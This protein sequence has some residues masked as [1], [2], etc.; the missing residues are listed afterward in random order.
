[1]GVAVGDPEPDLAR[2]VG[3]RPVEH[4]PH[5]PPGH[6]AAAVGRVDPHRDQ[7][8][9]VRDPVEGREAG[10]EAHRVAGHLHDPPR[11]TGDA[12]APAVIRIGPLPVEAGGEGARRVPQ[13][14]QAQVAQ[15]TRL[16]GG[17][18]ADADLRQAWSSSPRRWTRTRLVEPTVPGGAPATITTRA[19][20]WTRSV[21]SSARWTGRARACVEPTGGTRRASTPQLI[22]SWLRTA[23]PGGNASSGSRVCRRA[24]RRTVS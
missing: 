2:P 19:P 16:G 4:R 11:S 24:S 13:G 8:A 22:A 15:H 7:V 23:G 6:P 9:A 12:V 5:E 17:E 1:R 21:A 20:G 10:R 3:S 18:P 14:L